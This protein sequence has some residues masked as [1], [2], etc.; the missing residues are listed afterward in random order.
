MAYRTAHSTTVS[1]N[2]LSL[3]RGNRLLIND[4]NH[5]LAPGE[6]LLLTGPNGVGKT[7]LIRA[8]AGFI[9]PTRG[10]ITFADDSADSK[11][12]QPSGKQAKHRINPEA[13]HYIGH[14]NGIRASLTVAENL[15]FWQQYFAA[16]NTIS[17]TADAFRLKSLLHIPAGYLSAGQKRRLG[18]A[19]LTLIKRPVW[20][21]DE[22]TVS[23]DQLSADTL[24]KAAKN[25]LK[26]GG[27]IFAATHTPL[28]ID[29]TTHIELTPV[30]DPGFEE[31]IWE[32]GI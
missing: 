27:I 1:I 15:T 18:L 14:K 25:H 17:D 8:I 19:R 26:A 7:T 5:A 16:E 30:I 13:L 28:G 21:L 24:A 2:N 23:L 12:F 29:F 32:A 6:S 10:S 20:L 9:S 11:Q 22:P 4:F 31:T 3:K